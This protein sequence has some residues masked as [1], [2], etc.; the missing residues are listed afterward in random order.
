MPATAS[1]RRI[2]TEARRKVNDRAAGPGRAERG[3]RRRARCVRYH[4]EAR[5]GRIDRPRNGETAPAMAEGS[6][7]GSARKLP[8]TAKSQAP[9]VLL[10]GLLLLA[11]GATMTLR[12]Q[13]VAR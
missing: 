11:A 10:T 4:G 8:K 1:A 3:A 13:L 12:R 9:V 5:S 7:G 2:I 6:A